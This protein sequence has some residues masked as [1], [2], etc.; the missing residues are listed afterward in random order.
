MKLINKILATLCLTA[1]LGASAAQDC[2]VRLYVVPS[3]Q[4]DVPENVQNL[5]CTRLM[6]AVT[7]EGVSADGT[8]DQFFITGKF[9]TVSE[10]VV[11]GPPT[12]TS[13]VLN[14]TLYVGDLEGEQ[15]YSTKTF[16]I[17]GVGASKEKA[18]INALSNI[19]AQNKSFSAFVSAAKYK[20]IDYYDRNYQSLLAK[21]NTAASTQNYDEALYYT[22]RIPECS[23]GYTRAS[24]ATINYYNQYID[25]EAAQLISDAQAAWASSPDEYGAEKAMAFLM[26][27]N[28]ASS[29]YPKAQ[30]LINT[31]T[32]KIQRNWDFEHREK[33]KDQVDLK[34]RMIAAGRAVGVAY[35]RGQK[36]QR[37]N[38]MWI[39]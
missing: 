35:G 6:N 20:I 22:S 30:K 14:L 9:A 33:Y 8:Y 25:L 34:K 28:T 13:L 23:R 11:P 27:V 3:E 38:L 19:N 24:E 36:T 15:V 1:T 2:N 39:R 12:M 4:N 31:I 26:Q 37:I 10:N 21:A 32:A 7:E 18:Y 16:E 29:N 5:L 17:R